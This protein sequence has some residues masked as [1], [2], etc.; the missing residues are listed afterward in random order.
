MK[1]N[2]QK[3]R[4]AA[5]RLDALL[6]VVALLWIATSILLLALYRPAAAHAQHPGDRAPEHLARYVVPSA[7]LRV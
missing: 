4:R 3:Q 6:F 7:H 1:L 5:G 2:I